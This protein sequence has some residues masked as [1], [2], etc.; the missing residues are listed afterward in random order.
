MLK[1]VVETQPRSDQGIDE[2]WLPSLFNVTLGFY[3][4]RASS[5]CR[6]PQPDPAGR[7]QLV[8]LRP[9]PQFNWKVADI[10]RLGRTLLFDYENLCGSWWLSSWTYSWPPLLLSPSTDFRHVLIRDDPHPL[11]L[12]RDPEGWSIPSWT[13]PPTVPCLRRRSPSPS[14][15][16]GLCTCRF[17]PVEIRCC[18][19]LWPLG[20]GVDTHCSGNDLWWL[21]EVFHTNEPKP[22]VRLPIPITEF[23]QFCVHGAIH[24]WVHTCA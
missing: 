21:G 20:L 9:H 11:V 10:N 24:I 5:P 4:Y 2:F 13:W 19:R 1:S 18:G 23:T 17:T 12:E 22:T 8:T 16:N 7:A 15:L 6:G 3:R 14:W